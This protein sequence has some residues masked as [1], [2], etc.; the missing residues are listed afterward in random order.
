MPRL[1]YGELM[2]AE[3]RRRISGQAAGYSRRHGQRPTLATIRIGETRASRFHERARARACAE[4]GIDRVEE[5]LPPD[6]SKAEILALI[7]SLNQDSRV[8][9]ILCQL[10]VPLH[11]DPIELI[12]RI[13]PR[14][15]VD[16]LTIANA[17]RLSTG[18]SGLRPCTPL[19]VMLL[20]RETGVELRGAHAVVIGS[21]NLVGKPITQLMLAAGA[22]V[23]HC[24]K[25]SRRLAEITREADVLVAAVGQPEMVRGSWIKPGATV[26]DAGGSRRRSS[27]VGDV[28]Q[29][30]ALRVAGALAPVPGG[31]G[32]VTIACLM[33]NTLRAAHD[34]RSTAGVPLELLT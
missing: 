24:H 8:S 21:S 25:H 30:E 29:S 11:L 3:M 23:T 6:T 28:C 27:I 12:N 33:S 10:P 4:T 9:G 34:Q 7:D 22:T 17:G 31:V 13:D 16:G 20:L 14:K 18:A 19:A 32:P 2:A 26:I 15:D 5:Q 1:I